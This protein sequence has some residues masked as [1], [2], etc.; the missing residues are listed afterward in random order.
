MSIRRAQRQQARIRLAL[1]GASGSG[2]TFSALQI[3][4]GM[5]AWEKI[6][7][8]DTENNSADL[9]AHLGNFNVLP[10]K[11]PFTPENY[12][13]AIDE[14]ERS[15][16]QVIIID[17]LSHEWEGEGGILE[18]HGSLPGNSFTNWSKIT[19]RHNALIQRMLR[20]S[21]HI[22]A[23]LRTKQDYVLS[24]KNG[25]LVPEKVGLKS[26]TR[27]GMDYEFTVVLDM[28]VSHK[29]SASK[30]R[31]ELFS[32]KPSFQPSKS[33]GELISQ[34]CNSGV[35]LSLS[36]RINACS[37]IDDLKQLYA[38]SSEDEQFT[39]RRDF[40]LR[41]IQLKQK[42]QSNGISHH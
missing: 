12:I 36:A 38:I 18:Y 37:S 22:L 31:T 28:D 19:P 29:C 15:G 10:L 8:I 17:S 24:D 20:S 3:A 30:D 2:K 13:Q 39:Y 5:A 14:C 26:I 6:C 23:T 32:N 34:W 40:Q 4:S 25:K 42:V 33:T 7:I 41:Q 21:S 27:D 11:A 16:M 1:Q 35:Q 9:Y